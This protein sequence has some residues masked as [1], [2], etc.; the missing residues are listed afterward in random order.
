MSLLAY[1]NCYAQICM[2]VLN[3]PTIERSVARCQHVADSC[4]IQPAVLNLLAVPVFPL[5]GDFR[6][7]QSALKDIHPVWLA[8]AWL[9]VTTSTERR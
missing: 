1:G 9:S 8:A 4:A 3:K 2:N 7:E 5:D 6:R